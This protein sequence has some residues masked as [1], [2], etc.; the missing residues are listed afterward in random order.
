MSKKKDE[1]FKNIGKKDLT[2][3]RYCEMG[4]NKVS[5]RHGG[6]NLDCAFFKMVKLT[7]PARSRTS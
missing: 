2:N 4:S 7:H 1:K 5:F 3:Q 6:L